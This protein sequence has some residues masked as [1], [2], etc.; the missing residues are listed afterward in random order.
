MYERLWNYHVCDLG[1]ASG[2]PVLSIVKRRGPSL[3]PVE[4]TPS[5]HGQANVNGLPLL[6]HFE[7]SLTEPEPGFEFCNGMQ[8]FSA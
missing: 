4:E 5:N 6:R 1:N 2:S 8:C 3:P 7:L